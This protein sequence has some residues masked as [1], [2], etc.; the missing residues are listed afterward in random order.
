MKVVWKMNNKNYLLG[1]GRNDDCPCG[2]H[3]KFKFC[4]IDKIAGL[5][6]L[7]GQA[8]RRPVYMNAER[9]IARKVKRLARQKR[10][11]LIAR[12]TKRYNAKMK[13]R[14]YNEVRTN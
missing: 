1:L 2:S 3:Q 7:R 13:R 14:S 9:M 8:A 10:F 6:L 5:P 12:A 4:C 11:K